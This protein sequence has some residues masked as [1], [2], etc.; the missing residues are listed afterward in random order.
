MG[1]VNEKSLNIFLSIRNVFIFLYQK[2][3][4]SQYHQFISIELTICH[5]VKKSFITC[6]E[7]CFV[8]LSLLFCLWTPGFLESEITWKTWIGL[9]TRWV[10]WVVARTAKLKNDLYCAHLHSMS[11]SNVTNSSPRPSL[12]WADIV[13]CAHETYFLVSSYRSLG[14]YV[15][16]DV[17]K[18]LC[19][20]FFTYNA[21]VF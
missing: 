8:T 18:G 13:Q 4:L 16:P 7:E 10:S 11:V 6:F 12:G 14:S 17:L 19:F 9:R 15:K 3:N 2:K 21:T 5:T 20:V 1:T